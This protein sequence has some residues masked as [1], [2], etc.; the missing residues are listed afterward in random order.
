MHKE[1][2]RVRMCS[3]EMCVYVY[4]CAIH[5]ALYCAQNSNVAEK[6]SPSIEEYI[7][8]LTI[9]K[10]CFGIENNRN[11]NKH[12]MNASTPYNIM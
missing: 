11:I 5:S 10:K 4:V 8:M 2:V 1:Y 12:L 3:I 6:L 9:E 7:H